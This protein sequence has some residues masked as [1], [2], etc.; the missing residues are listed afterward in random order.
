MIAVILIVGAVYLLAFGLF[1]LA[2]RRAPKGFEDDRG[3]HPGRD[4]PLD[5]GPDATYKVK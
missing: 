2:V 1:L 5:V 4:E 3:F